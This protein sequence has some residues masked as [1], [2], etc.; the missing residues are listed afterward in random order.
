M[1]CTSAGTQHVRTSADNDGLIGIHRYKEKHPATPTGLSDTVPKPVAQSLS[2]SNSQPSICRF[3][4]LDPTY[5]ALNMHHQ[6]CTQMP[7]LYDR[8]LPGPRQLEIGFVYCSNTNLQASYEA[9]NGS[10]MQFRVLL[11]VQTMPYTC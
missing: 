6:R 5:A 1:A 11:D 8:S 7:Q 9:S 4:R 10:T 2:I 3:S